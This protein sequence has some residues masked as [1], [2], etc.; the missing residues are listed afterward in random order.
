MGRPF[1]S[2]FL[3]PCWVRPMLSRLF[4]PSHSAP[5]KPIS[6]RFGTCWRTLYTQCTLLETP[7]R[8]LLFTRGSP[9]WISEV[10]SSGTWPEGSPRDP[11]SLQSAFLQGWEALKLQTDS[12]TLPSLST[13][14]QSSAALRQVPHTSRR[15]W[16][17]VTGCQFPEASPTEPL[18]N[19]EPP[20]RW[21][22]HARSPSSAVAIIC[23]CACAAGYGHLSRL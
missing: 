2:H 9:T 20:G 6:S 10:S 13:S 3:N 14:E 22:R 5:A 16:W 23:Q 18:G 8:P 19:K 21:R 4:L 1:S 7:K 17:P 15:A 12:P 11:A